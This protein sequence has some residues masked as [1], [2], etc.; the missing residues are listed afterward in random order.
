[1]RPAAFFRRSEAEFQFEALEAAE[2][3]LNRMRF[4]VDCLVKNWEKELKYIESSVQEKYPLP[5][6]PLEDI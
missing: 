5:T 6:K 3:F 1:M 4:E 2:E